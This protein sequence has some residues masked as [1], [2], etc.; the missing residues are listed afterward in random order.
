MRRITEAAHELGCH[1]DTLRNLERRGH[2]EPMRDWAGQ[3]RYSEKDMARLRALLFPSNEAEHAND[4]EGNSE[5]GA[6]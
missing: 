5:G 2:I 3:R 1:A 6:D 4:A